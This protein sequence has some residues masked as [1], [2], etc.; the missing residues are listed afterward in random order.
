MELAAIVFGGL[1]LS[2]LNPPAKSPKSSAHQFGES[3]EKLLKDNCGCEKGK[4]K[5]KD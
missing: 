3:L 2:I 1:I 5:D 4:D